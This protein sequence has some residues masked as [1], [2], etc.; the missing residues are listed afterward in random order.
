MNTTEHWTEPQQQKYF[1]AVFLPQASHLIGVGNIR[2]AVA[3]VSHTIVVPVPLVDV[4]DSR[5]VVEKITQTCEENSLISSEM[6]D[7]RE[8]SEVRLDVGGLS[9]ASPVGRR[10]LR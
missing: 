1:S 5:A 3:G 10:R 6:P 7:G 9:N 2:A 8:M 4:G